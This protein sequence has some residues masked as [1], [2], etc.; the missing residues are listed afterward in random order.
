MDAIRFND[1]TV[2]YR[3]RRGGAHT[4]LKNFDLAVRDQEFISLVG[5]SGCG[6]ST[7]LR[8]AARL[9]APTSGSIALEGERTLRGFERVAIVFQ[10]PNLLP[11]LNVLDNILYPVRVLRRVSQEDRARAS[12]LLKMVGLTD[13]S[14]RAPEELSGGMQQRVA[15]CRALVLNPKILLM[16][17][18]FSALDALTREEIQFELRRIH[19]ATR[20]TTLFVTH[21]VSEAVLLSDRI[22]IMSSAV[23]KA[24][25]LCQIE[26][27]ERSEDVLTT[28]KFTTY[29]RRVRNGIYGRSD[30]AVAA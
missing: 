4:A 12:A 17:E 3:T 14:Q 23:G 29:A 24:P 13:A 5:P 10:R 30:A 20:M 25:I 26:L 19:E 6:K 22:A 16:D 8:A 1:V 11:W 28:E 18:P 21:S 9:I 2:Q 15:I 27:N 7:V